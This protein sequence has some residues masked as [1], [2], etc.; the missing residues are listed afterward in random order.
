[1]NKICTS[2]PFGAYQTDKQTNTQ[3]NKQSINC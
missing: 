3:T 2:N 1:M